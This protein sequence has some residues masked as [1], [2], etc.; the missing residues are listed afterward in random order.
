[1][2]QPVKCLLCQPENLCLGPQD[3]SK[4]HTE[5]EN[6]K[7]QHQWTETGNPRSSVARNIAEPAGSGFS[8]KAIPKTKKVT[9]DNT[10]YWPLVSTCTHMSPQAHIRNHTHTLIHILSPTHYAHTLSLTYT[11]ICTNPK[12]QRYSRIK[13][14]SLTAMSTFQR[15]LQS[16]V[17]MFW[18]KVNSNHLLHLEL[19]LC[20]LCIFNFHLYL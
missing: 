11:H 16:H 3:P 4:E 2:A 1:M 15:R 5:V 10:H 8:E 14:N 7:P 6:L 9:E 19:G 17:V 18:L 20:Q 12:T 13:N